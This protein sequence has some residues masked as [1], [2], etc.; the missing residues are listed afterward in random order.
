MPRS[1]PP[2]RSEI[3]RL[4]AL[5]MVDRALGKA[6][7]HPR[8]LQTI[9]VL[10]GL[11]MVAFAFRPLIIPPSRSGA[12]EAQPIASSAVSPAAALST[13]TAT[14]Y[15]A[16][17]LELVMAYNQASIRAAVLNTPNPMAGYL[18]PD[19]AAWSEVQTEYQRRVASSETHEPALTRWG[20]LRLTLDGDTATVETQEHWDDITRIS[21]IVVASKRGIL[22][23][24]TYELRRAPDT[25]DWRITTVTS[26][27]L[28]G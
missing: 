16:V 7:A 21:G 14:S 19:G 9:G 5:S 26:T 4:L 27:T 12:T 11:L 15:E 18:A 17:V 23:H 20:V 22:T 10:L 2:A 8:L 24:N 6:L 13:A 28:I 1:T 25:S 3:D